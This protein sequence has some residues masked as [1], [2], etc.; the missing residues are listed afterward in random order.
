MQVHFISASCE[1]MIDGKGMR[2]G[3]VLT[4]ANGKTV[5]VNF[6][7]L[8]GIGYMKMDMHCVMYVRHCTYHVKFIPCFGIFLMVKFSRS[9]IL[10]IY[11]LPWISGSSIKSWDL[12]N[13]PSI[14]T[15][16]TK[17]PLA[18]QN[19]IRN[20]QFLLHLGKLKCSPIIPDFSDR[21]V[22]PQTPK[23][24]LQTPTFQFQSLFCILCYMT[25]HIDFDLLQYRSI[26]RM[27]RGGSH[28]LMPY[29]LPKKNAG[30]NLLWTLQLWLEPRWW[31]LG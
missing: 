7:L 20:S 17:S 24:S 12:L 18:L 9:Y 15:N 5:E 10:L 4:A 16:R 31:P 25:L 13:F 3:D 26:I 29:G 30:P 11:I 22:K 23:E 2:S 14:N 1:N 8:N 19:W 21:R 28:L 27:Q 6:H